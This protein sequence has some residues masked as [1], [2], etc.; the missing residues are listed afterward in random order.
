[1]VQQS[2]V[3]QGLQACNEG[4]HLRR[5]ASHLQPLFR[6][7]A[8]GY[9]PRLGKNATPGRFS[10]GVSPHARTWVPWR[11]TAHCPSLYSASSSPCSHSLTPGFT[12]QPHVVQAR[13]PRQPGYVCNKHTGNTAPL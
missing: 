3:L 12:T 6:S 5:D 2:G 9:V 13:L 7:P 1:M 8:N 11:S 10:R 4:E